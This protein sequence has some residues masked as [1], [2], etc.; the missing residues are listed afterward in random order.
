MPGQGRDT[1]YAGLDVEGRQFRIHAV[2]GDGR[3]SLRRWVTRKDLMAV[4]SAAEARIIGLEYRS[5]AHDLAFEL[6]QAGFEPRLIRFRDIPW[7]GDGTEDAAFD[8]AEALCDAVRTG[9]TRHVPVLAPDQ[10]G[11][12]A[13]QR[14]RALLKRQRSASLSAARNLVEADDP[15]RCSAA[16]DERD[17]EHSLGAVAETSAFH[18]ASAALLEVLRVLDQAIA[19]L[20][21]AEPPFEVTGSDARRTV[22]R[23]GFAAGSGFGGR[24][25]TPRYAAPCFAQADRASDLRA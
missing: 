20:E 8:R 1:I 15:R 17:I 11:R 2:D 6:L 24:G 18:Q 13:S 7:L 23:E 10:Q 14:V 9:S 21:P 25:T 4:L 22:E 5:A 12:A 16:R 3:L 19:A